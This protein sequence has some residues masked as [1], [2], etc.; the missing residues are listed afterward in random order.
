MEK[1]CKMPGN[2]GLC[3]EGQRVG[4][5]KCTQRPKAKAATG[6]NYLMCDRTQAIYELIFIS[7]KTRRE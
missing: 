3:Q 5:L 7:A 1:V 2:L 6:H 4:K